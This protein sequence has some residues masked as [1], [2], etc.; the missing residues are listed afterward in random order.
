MKTALCGNIGIPFTS[1]AGILDKDSIAVLE[2]SSFQLERI[3]NFRPYISI[4]LNIADDHLDR[5]ADMNEY[6]KAKNKVFMNQLK[7]DYAIANY[8]QARFRG[9]KS[10]IE[11]EVLFF[12]SKK[13]P[14]GMDGAYIEK[15]E[16]IIRKDN[17]YTWL[18]SKDSLSLIGEHNTENALASGLACF[19]IGADP[20]IIKDVLCSFRGLRHRFELVSTV[21]GIKFIDDSKATN[22]N[23]AKRAIQASSKG[24][25][26]IAGG[27]DK[28]GDY[29]A[30]SKPLK[31]KVKSMFLIGEAKERIAS[32]LSNIVPTSF[33]TTLEHAVKEAFK[34]AKS[35]DTILLA[36]MCSSFDMFKDYK[37]R[38]EVFCKVV[39]ELK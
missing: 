22:I 33:A 38:G 13:L 23:S 10:S 17:K 32:S 25:I 37:E 1:I 21:K 35:G 39:Q 34:T 7:G 26:L 4:M 5:Y 12:S 20:D 18:A 14:K 27:K 24:I 9:L 6:E 16:L 36:P 29:K 8:E 31:E 3:E 15:E 11:P 30:L 2:V 19:L 28:G